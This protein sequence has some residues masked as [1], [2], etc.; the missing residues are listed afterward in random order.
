MFSVFFVRLGSGRRLQGPVGP[1]QHL[2]HSASPTPF[3]CCSS[4]PSI[5]RR[6]WG[7]WGHEAPAAGKNNGRH[8]STYCPIKKTEFYSAEQSFL[9]LMIISSPSL[10]LGHYVECKMKLWT[11]C[12]GGREDGGITTGHLFGGG[13]FHPGSAA[14]WEQEHCS[15]ST[16]VSWSRYEVVLQGPTGRN[17][18]YSQT[19]KIVLYLFMYASMAY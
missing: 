10:F 16:T 15:R 11:V 12:V 7:W 14:A 17:P 4:P 8:V 18:G 19:S 9:Q 2:L 1:Q 5:R 3:L 6:Q 13:V